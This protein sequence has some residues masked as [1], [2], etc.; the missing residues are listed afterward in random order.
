VRALDG[1]DLEVYPR[2]IHAL[3]GDNGAGKSSMIKALSGAI[4]PDEGTI[5]IDGVEQHFTTPRDAQDAG[6]ETVYQDL[7]LASTLDASDN[8]FIGRERMATGWRGFLRFVDRPAMRQEVQEQLDKLGIQLKSLRAP[9][10]SLS[11]GQ[12]QA[13]AVA[14]A[15]VWGSRVLILDEPAAAL[16][17]RQTEQVLQLIERVRD[18][19][20]LSVILITH[21]LPEVFRV[22]DR[23]SV[24]RLGRRVHVADVAAS[25]TESLIAAMAG[26]SGSEF[27]EEMA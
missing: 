26:V 22:A 19:Q 10:G 25:T 17:V 27:R 1:A 13:V 11:G 24:M 15:A 8:V 9:V 21:A 5:R 2:E 14:R 12:R 4:V 3:V 20:G 16:G 7:A 6:I 18:E 23:V